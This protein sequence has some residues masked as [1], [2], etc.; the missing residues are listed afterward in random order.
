MFIFKIRED[1]FKKQERDIFLPYA[2]QL[3]SITSL[4]MNYDGKRDY[5]IRYLV[6]NKDKKFIGYSYFN[7]KGEPLFGKYS[8]HSFTPE[9]VILDLKKAVFVPSKVEICIVPLIE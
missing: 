4:D 3:L 1:K 2:N 8:H 9:T 6:K 5:F 7:S